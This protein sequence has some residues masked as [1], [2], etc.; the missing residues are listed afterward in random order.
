MGYQP[1]GDNG[2]FL[3]PVPLIELGQEVRRAVASTSQGNRLVL[4]AGNG[5]EADLVLGPSA[6]K[7][8]ESVKD[9]GLVFAGY[10]ITAPEYGWDDYKDPDVRGKVVVLMNFNPPFQGPGVRLWYGRW[11][12]KYENAARHGARVARSIHT[13]ESAGG[14]RPGVGTSP[15]APRHDPPPAADDKFMEF[16]G[17]ITESAA[18]RLM[19]L[20]GK[21]LDELRRSA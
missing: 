12:Y 16:R 10:G 5:M 17:W 19:Q 4:H 13:T 7:D 1:A 2:T 20:T 6:H 15:S 3:Q 8:R 11:D 21:D 18:I 14:P 9:A